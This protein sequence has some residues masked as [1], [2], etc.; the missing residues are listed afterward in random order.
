MPISFET[1]QEL[2]SYDPETGVLR[3]LVHR[4]R[5]TAGSVAGTL[6]EKGY[7]RVTIDGCRYRAHCIIWLLMTGEWPPRGIDHED[8]DESNNKWINLRL[9]NKS[10]NAMNYT[11]ESGTRGIS[12]HKVLKVWQAYIKRLS[13]RK[14][15]GCF[16]DK[17]DALI[18]YNYHAAY[19]FGPFARLNVVSDYGHD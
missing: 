10:Q 4:G 12:F 1:A 13:K 5:V 14:H 16:A 7:S 18:C 3:W 9:A 17:Q 8:T 2:F 11:K 6:D 19:L 15:L